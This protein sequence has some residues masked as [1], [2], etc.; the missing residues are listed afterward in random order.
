MRSRLLT[1]NARPFGEH[2][3]AAASSGDDAPL[4]ASDR[5]LR[6]CYPARFGQFRE[7]CAKGASTKWSG[8]SMS[9]RVAPQT[10]FESMTFWLTVIVLDFCELP[11]DELG[12][13][14]RGRTPSAK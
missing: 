5:L 14:A 2:E 13:K 8:S 6:E 7:K 4:V 11:S 1:G 12:R 9:R 10:G 3:K